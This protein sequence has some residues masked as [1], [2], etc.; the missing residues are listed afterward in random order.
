MQ[1]LERHQAAD[2]DVAFVRTP[3]E[4]ADDLACIDIA[5]EPLV[6]AL[7]STHLLSRRQRIRR[8]ALADVPLV[9]FP[10]R[11]SPEVY[12]RSL[13]QVYGSA[14]PD[15]V[16]TEPTEESILVA[17]AEGMGITLLV[18]ERADTLLYSGV[19]SAFF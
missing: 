13:A 8:E 15:I 12:G 1:N 11:S 9:Y 3:F 18:E 14:A 16:R 17:V 4:N 10:R 7:P 2:L 6:I 19:F 5:A